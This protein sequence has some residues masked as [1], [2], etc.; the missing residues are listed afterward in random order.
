DDN[1]FLSERYRRNMKKTTPTGMFY[2]RN[3]DGKWV[4]GD[5]VIYSDF[6]ISKHKINEDELSKVRM[7]RYFCG[8]DWGYG[9]YGATV[10][11]GVDDVENYYIVEEHAHQYKESGEWVSIAKEVVSKYGDIPFYA[12][13]ARP[14]YVFR[15]N[16]E[17]INAINANKTVRSEEYTSELQSRF[18]IVCRL[19]LEKKK[20]D[21]SISH[22]QV[23]AHAPTQVPR[24]NQDEPL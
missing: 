9:H 19:L 18:D 24:H 15:F 4:S 2:E 16:E 20:P 5:G 12:D 14:E 6:N 23:F 17:G 1:T 13:S 3:I 22:Q 8:V 21:V 7:S 11:I 10:V